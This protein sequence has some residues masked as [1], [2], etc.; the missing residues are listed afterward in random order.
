ME[1]KELE[2][3]V[4]EEQGVKPI[5]FEW[6]GTTYTLEFN[7]NTAKIA[8]TQFDISVDKIRSGCITLA[9]DMFYCALLMHHPN[10]KTSVAEQMFECLG[11][12]S[13]LF[14][15]LFAMYQYAVVSIF[16]EPEQGN[17]ISW[18]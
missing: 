5:T 17:V 9:P 6:N 18:K 1:E 3:T 7:R 11:D 16:E 8:E 15:R 14:A 4:K 10:I 2:T 12:K 13:T